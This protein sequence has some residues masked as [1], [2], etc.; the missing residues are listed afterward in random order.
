MVARVGQFS[1]RGASWISSQ[2]QQ[3]LQTLQSTHS[4]QG[5]LI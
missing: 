1:S 5:G 4:L 3:G 2:V